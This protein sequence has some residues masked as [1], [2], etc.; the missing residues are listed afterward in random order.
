MKATDEELYTWGELR[1]TPEEVMN[2]RWSVLPGLTGPLPKPEL[3]EAPDTRSP[4]AYIADQG[5]C[6][7]GEPNHA[8]NKV[9][10]ISKSGKAVDL[11]AAL[12]AYSGSAT[13]EDDA[14]GG[15]DA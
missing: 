7:C 3:R 10:A 14:K 9:V 13:D 8:H 2:S 12:E 1:M 5:A 4:V 6:S 15:D 11:D